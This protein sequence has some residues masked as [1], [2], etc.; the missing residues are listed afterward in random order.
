VAEGGLQIRTSFLPDCKLRVVERDESCR[1][2]IKK[3]NGDY[4]IIQQ[5]KGSGFDKAYT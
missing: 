3:T 2:R 1:K 4:I 5:S